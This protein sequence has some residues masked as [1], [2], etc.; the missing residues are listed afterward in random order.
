MA[1]A[2]KNCRY[3]SQ[4]KEC[5]AKLKNGKAPGAD[6]IVD[7]FPTYGGEGMITVVAMLYS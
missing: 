7:E 6:D 5:V 3:S 1:I 4:V 2:L